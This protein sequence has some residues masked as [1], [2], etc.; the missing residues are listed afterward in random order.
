MEK[1]LLTLWNSGSSG[2][3]KH[4]E[5]AKAL[6]L[7]TKQT[8]RYIKK[9]ADQGWLE[10]TAGRGR[11]N[12]SNLVW[13]KDV[14]AIYEDQVM[15][16]I[17]QEAVEESSKYLLYDWS[18]DSKLRLLNQFRLRFGYFQSADEIDKLIVPRRHK[19]LTLHPL[20]A[21]DMQSAN[22]VANVF[23]RL[24]AVDENGVI[25]PELAH[26]WDVGEF[27]LRLYLHK[28]VKF[29]DGSTLTADDVVTCLNRLRNHVYFNSLWEPVAEVKSAAPLVVDLF[30]P[31]GCSYCLQLLGMMNSSIYKES[32]G[33]IWGTG[34]FY[35]AE[36]SEDKTSLKAFDEYFQKRP[37]L[38]V[39]DFVQVPRD[40]EITYRS[41]SHTKEAATFQVESDTGFGVVV[42]N[43]FRS[44]DI[45]RQEVRGYIH[46]VIAKHRRT[47]SDYHKRALPNGKSCLVG[48]D[49]CFTVPE[50][51]RPH[52]NQALVLKAVK[53]SEQSALWLKEALE[54]EGVPVKVHWMSFA[55]KLSDHGTD[56]Q[57]DLF[58]H[59]EVLEMNQNFSFFYFLKNSYSPLAGAISKHKEVLDCLDQYAQTP[60]AQWTSLNLQV[61]KLLL[62]SS[63]MI[64]LY[65]EKRHVP[66]SADLMNIKISHFGYVDYSNLWVRPS[67]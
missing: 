65:Y 20:K 33:R 5:I 56:Q 14:E 34:A 35:E 58:I 47:I 57:G 46:Y 64:P 31:E 42:M 19:L 12:L 63:I 9:W 66:F 2:N 8:T 61:E 67:I 7:S 21:I 25:K 30:F 11:G 17:N 4:E 32:N 10:Y 60:F 62:E 54:Q 27:H 18:N 24:V 50:M 52:F 55:E 29:H 39:V 40:F 26:A 45:Q 1:Q 3:V 13:L 48:Y 51:E 36:N 16:I 59:G 15:T 53:H 22:M 28:G 6:D 43:A 41:S 44:T 23:N 38:D 49:Q 37:L